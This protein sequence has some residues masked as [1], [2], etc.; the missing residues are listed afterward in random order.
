MATLK[1]LILAACAGLCSC[2]TSPQHSATNR[3]QEDV[4]VSKVN[5]V[6]RWALDH[7]AT[8]LWLK[9]PQRYKTGGGG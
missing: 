8:V 9:Y 3:W 2:A 6:D 4:D 1:L 7:G 5:S